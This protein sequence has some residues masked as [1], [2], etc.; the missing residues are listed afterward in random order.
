MLAEPPDL[1]LHLPVL[2]RREAN[3]AAVDAWAGRAGT[4]HSLQWSCLLFYVY[5][6]GTFQ[7]CITQPRPYKY[8]VCCIQQVSIEFLP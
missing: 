3:P 8:V 4:A 2:L 5:Q 6:I 7:S 1:Q